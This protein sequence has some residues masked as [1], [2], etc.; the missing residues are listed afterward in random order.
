[1]FLFRHESILICSP[2][3]CNNLFKNLNAGKQRRTY[4]GT[5]QG[6]ES[7]GGSVPQGLEKIRQPMRR[8]IRLRISSLLKLKQ[9]GRVT[10]L[11]DGVYIST[12]ALV[13]E[14]LCWVRLRAST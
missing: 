6:V 10:S 3:P 5:L 13:Y 4:N 11:V 7:L 8:E 2:R 14:Y 1:M 12:C 9:L